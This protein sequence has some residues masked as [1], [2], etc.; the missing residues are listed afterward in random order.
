MIDVDP[1]IGRIARTAAVACV[2]A[3]AG[4]LLLRPDRPSLAAGIVGGGVLVF[5]SLFAIRGS[6][7]AV[8]S[9]AGAP[10]GGGPAA[11]GGTGTPGRAG[12]ATAVKLAGRFALLALAAYVMIAR[13]RLHPV[14][15]LIG[16]SSLVAG[17]T[18]EAVR[19]L[20]RP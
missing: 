16:A 5:V 3:T 2:A 18:L 14:G 9:S 7:D 1:V 6:I 12:A 8:L 10:D 15:L 19:G 4:A 17:A 13:L 20:R 11:A